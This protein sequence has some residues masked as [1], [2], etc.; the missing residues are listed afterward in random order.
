M[1][2][3]NVLESKKETSPTRKPTL[4]VR[5]LKCPRPFPLPPHCM[6]WGTIETH[7]KSC[8]RLLQSAAQCRGRNR[9]ADRWRQAGGASQNARLR[10]YCLMSGRARGSV[11]MPCPSGCVTNDGAPRLDVPVVVGEVVKA[12]VRHGTTEEAAMGVACA[13]EG[14]DEVEPAA[15][16]QARSLRTTR[17]ACSPDG[18]LTAPSWGWAGK[19][20]IRPGGRGAPEQRMDRRDRG[21]PLKVAVLSGV[22]VRPG[23][24]RGFEVVWR[25]SPGVGLGV[26]AVEVVGRAEA[27]Q[28]AERRAH[29]LM[30]ARR[31]DST[32]AL[33]ESR[34]SLAVGRGEP[35]PCR[36][37][38]ARARR[39]VIDRAR[40]APDRLRSVRILGCARSRQS[41]F[42]PPGARRGAL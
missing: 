18:A 38:R 37:R 12:R 41:G 29:V 35:S 26:A 14:H 20:S 23:D 9:S 7:S 33:A 3:S 4:T 27:P 25:V 19:S 40:R 11:C 31:E 15:G 28:R 1:G 8:P 39:T 36:E 34:D 32:A 6:G 17:A 21:D 16:R 30:V 42:L 2:D 5:G 24:G 13:L 22:V 10:T